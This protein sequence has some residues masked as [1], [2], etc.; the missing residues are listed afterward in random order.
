MNR[1]CGGGKLPI[2]VATKKEDKI[3]RNEIDKNVQKL[4]KETLIL[5]RDLAGKDRKKYSDK[6]LELGM[7]SPKGIFK[8]K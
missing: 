1:S 6:L 7:I 4:V 3:L 2:I 5:L 8:I